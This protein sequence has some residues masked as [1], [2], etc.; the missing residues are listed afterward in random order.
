VDTVTEMSLSAQGLTVTLGEVLG[1]DV[2]DF[3]GWLVEL[4]LVL[5]DALLLL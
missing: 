3:D 4:W 2:A 1:L 5:D